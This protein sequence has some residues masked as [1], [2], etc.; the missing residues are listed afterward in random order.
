MTQKTFLSLMATVAVAFGFNSCTEEEKPVKPQ[1][2]ETVPAIELAD[3][4]QSSIM[5]P[6]GSSDPVTINFTTTA[7]ADELVIVTEKGNDWCSAEFKDET[8][9]LIKPSKENM[10]KASQAIFMIENKVNKYTEGVEISVNRG[11]ANLKKRDPMR[12]VNEKDQDIHLTVGTVEPYLMEVVC[13]FPIE[14]LVIVVECDW[15]TAEFEDDTHI[16]IS[17][18]DV[19]RLEDKTVTFTV[20][21][22]EEGTTKAG[23]T[24]YI[25]SEFSFKVSRPACEI[26]PTDVIDFG[27]GFTEYMMIPNTDEKETIY[28]TYNFDWNKVTL[29]KADDSNWCTAA[30]TEEG[31]VITP[32]RFEKNSTLEAL[33]ELTYPETVDAGDRFLQPNKQMVKV[34]KPAMPAEP[35]VKV[36]GKGV[37]WSYH[38][39]YECALNPAGGE[40]E[41]KIFTNQPQWYFCNYYNVNWIYPQP[42][43]GV[44]GNSVILKYSANTTGDY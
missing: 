22:K 23:P 35:Y 5:I 14:E 34:I 30:L 17:P 41:I 21:G 29:K 12:I 16:K 26:I 33:F 7:K 3:P 36:L 19:G 28:G 1:I 27:E 10:E 38:N 8:T 20:K 44:N 11:P 9:I 24:I 40:L 15:C 25:P 37:Q 39:F 2:P 43:E 31:V 4:S 13:Y 18:K 32:S 42:E 6:A